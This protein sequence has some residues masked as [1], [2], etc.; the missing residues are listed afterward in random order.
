MG[1]SSRAFRFLFDSR[2]YKRTHGGNEQKTMCSRCQMAPS[3]CCPDY[4]TVF[5]VLITK[6]LQAR[7][8][9]EY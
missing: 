1:L 9:T 5:E 2:V 4:H 3:I 8:D 6:K 7:L